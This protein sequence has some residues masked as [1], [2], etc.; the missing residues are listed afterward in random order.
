[1]KVLLIN[2]SPHKEGC[3]YTA[4]SEIAAE[5]EKC[6]VESE[7]FWL[8]TQPMSSC[9][10]CGA[11]KKTGKCFMDD[12]VNEFIAR[13]AEFD[14]FVFGSPV[15]F[16]GATGAISSFMS[17]AF[18]SGRAVLEGKPGACISSARRGG[19]TATF[20]QLN[21]FLTISNMVVVGSQYWNMVHGNTPDEVRQDGEGLQTMRTLGR[22]M[23]WIMQCIQAGKEAGIEFPTMQEEKIR[24]NFIR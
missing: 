10:G 8:G 22:N 23:A 15:H 24:T 16:A 11:C 17:R 7:I 18:Y 3:T 5:L 1:M 19:C 12:A 14:D 13:A 20:D 9:L 4:L 21:K 6:G 2:G